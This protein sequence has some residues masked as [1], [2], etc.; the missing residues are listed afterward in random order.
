[1][2]STTTER[3]LLDV[4]VLLALAVAEHVHH[5]SAVLW[6]DAQAAHASWATTPLTEA[7]LVRLLL[8]ERVYGAALVAADALGVLTSMRAIPGWSFLPDD[9][10]LADPTLDL[11]SMAGHRQVNDFHLLNL[12]VQHEHTLVTFDRALPTYLTGPLRDR[13]LLVP[14]S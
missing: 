5:D 6:F 4:N 9:S 13:V 12:A 7:A 14:V 1:M 11:A 3:W 2:P 10:S 8:N